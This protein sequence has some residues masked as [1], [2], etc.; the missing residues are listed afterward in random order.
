LVITDGNNGLNYLI[1]YFN[2]TTG[3][4]T[5]RPLTVTPVD[6]VL[7]INKCD[8]LPV[9][10]FNY[11]GT[12]TGDIISCSVTVLR[13][14]DNF[15]Y[16]ANSTV[17]AGKYYTNPVLCNSNYT[18]TSLTP[19]ILY[20]NPSG[21]GTRAVKPVLNCVQKLSGTGLNYVAN[22]SYKNDNSAD[23]YI[24]VGVNNLLS[25][26]YAPKDAQPV[27]FKSGGGSFNVNF[28]GKTLTWTV[29]STEENHKVSMAANAN[30]SST[31]CG[32]TA[33]S[34]MVTA[35]DTIMESVKSE[36]LP[37]DLIAY[38]NPVTDI[39]NISMQGIENYETV[40]VYDFSGKS[41]P[42]T[43]RA[44]NAD[45]LEIDMSALSPGRYFVSIGFKTTYKT[46]TVIKL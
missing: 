40:K 21:P 13:D 9:I 36:V 8:P 11:S 4:I 38:P 7:V 28:D 42:V 12:I 24:P 2:N 31:K 27:L 41:Q 17:S 6:P 46:F 25:G 43:F 35:P 19:G 1:K 44:K 15:A 33:K 3:I 23:V 22:F 16:V 34:A 32:A 5:A 14:K 10:K 29:A 37:I 20:V 30:S 26:N 39:V 45:L 18:F